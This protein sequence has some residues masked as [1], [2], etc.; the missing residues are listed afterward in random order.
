M[1][2]TVPL[3]PRSAKPEPN[4]RPTLPESLPD[5]LGRN[6]APFVHVSSA[7]AAPL[8]SRAP[9]PRRPSRSRSGGGGIG[10]RLLRQ[11]PCSSGRSRSRSVSALGVNLAPRRGPSSSPAAGPSRNPKPVL[12]RGPPRGRGSDVGRG[13]SRRQFPMNL[14]SSK[15]P[16]PKRSRSRS[17]SRSFAAG[18]SDASECLYI[19]TYV[20]LRR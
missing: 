3:P 16:P 20:V 10:P 8:L 6:F 12:P 7:S 2:L 15:P 5:G 1:P 14:S 11:S 9:N 13:P 17:R 18:K 4:L 19:E